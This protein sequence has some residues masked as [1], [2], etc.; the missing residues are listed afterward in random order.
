MTLLIWMYPA[1]LKHGLHIRWNQ[2]FVTTKMHAKWNLGRQGHQTVLA[3]HSV[4]TRMCV[5]CWFLHRATQNM[6]T[7]LWAAFYL[8]SRL[9]PTLKSSA[10]AT[11]SFPPCRYDQ[12]LL[13]YALV[14]NSLRG[15]WFVAFFS[16]VAECCTL[17]APAFL[18]VASGMYACFPR[19]YSPLCRF[20]WICTTGIVTYTIWNLAVWISLITIVALIIFLQRG[21]RSD[22]TAGKVW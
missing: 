21:R 11:T 8:I 3:A 5:A 10:V 14:D 19:N 6:E 20:C 12:I 1:V 7:E 18:C 9:P 16:C 22:K 15:C 17:A 13:V 4:V 2:Q